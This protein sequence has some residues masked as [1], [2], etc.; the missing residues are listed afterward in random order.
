MAL[1]S[2][3]KQSDAPR[4]RQAISRD[5]ERSASDDFD[6]RYSFRRNRTL[7]GSSSSQIT[8]P[9][10]SNAQMKSP[11]VQAHELTKQRRHIG[12]TLLL[13]LVSAGVLY[14]LLSQLTAGVVVRASDLS[15]Q[16]DPG[17]EKVIQAYLS[18]QPIE[19]LRFM[20]N[21]DHLDQYLQSKAPEVASVSIE[22]SAGFGNTSFILTLRQPIVGW[23]IDGHQ[24]YVDSTGTAFTR[25]YFASPSVQVVDKSGVQIQAGQAIASNR[26]LGFVGRAVAITKTQGFTVTQV[27]IPE[28]TTRQVELQL[29]GV[30][31][32]VKL[33]IDRGVGVQVEDM[34]RAIHWLQAHGQSPQYLDV[35]VSGEAFYR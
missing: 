8:S 5:E 30:S 29:N 33:S 4:R 22:G 26:F 9:S 21:L 1:F 3:K 31:Y 6:E 10:E 7:T 12:V 18:S 24:E 11:R 13:V 20:T 34:V 15:M 14:G 28:G 23:S 2:R 17:Y 27:I 19:R 35:R 25:N 32:P 16:L